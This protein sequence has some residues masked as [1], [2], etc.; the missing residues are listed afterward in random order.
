MNLELNTISTA[1]HK[2]EHCLEKC[3]VILNNRFNQHLNHTR[4]DEGIASGSN[5]E[6]IKVYFI[7]KT[8]QYVVTRIKDNTSKTVRTYTDILYA[9]SELLDQ[10]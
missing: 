6:V 8:K 2:L 9:V 4:L 7:D 5:R 1:T 10:Q 3:E